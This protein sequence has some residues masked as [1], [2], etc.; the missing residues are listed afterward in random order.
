MSIS[1]L[2]VNGYEYTIRSLE[3]LQQHLTKVS[4]EAY[5]ELDLTVAEVCNLS[6]LINRERLLC[7]AD[8]RVIRA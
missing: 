6:A 7:L 4:A 1:I 3:E 2:S 5:G 8:M